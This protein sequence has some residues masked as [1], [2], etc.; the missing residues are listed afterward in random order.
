MQY[1]A[2]VFLGSEALRTRFGYQRRL[3]LIGKSIVN[4][5]GID[6]GVNFS[7]LSTES[8]HFCTKMFEPWYTG[9][10]AD[11][12]IMSG[13]WWELAGGIAGFLVICDYILR[14]TKSV[15]KKAT[16]WL[17]QQ[18]S[19]QIPRETIRIVA[20]ERESF[21]ANGG[22]V[23]GKPATQVEARFVAT[24]IVNTP[25][26]ILQARIRSPKT[27]AA[28]ILVRHPDKNIYGDY[29]LLPRVPTPG[30][31]SF[32]LEPPIRKQKGE[33]FIATIVLT[34]NLG[35]E[36]PKKLTFRSVG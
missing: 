5:I 10:V 4:V 8:N 12:R 24:N 34:D 29:A 31:A 18:L 19:S 9:A 3:L 7:S 15:L 16:Q 32:F 22:S 14:G 28:M 30:S 27:T 20:N 36:H 11:L 21:W 13:H 33:D 6:R 35:N 17:Q 23:A 1:F 26:Q 2:S 25:V